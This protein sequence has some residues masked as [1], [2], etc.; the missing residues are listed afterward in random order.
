MFSEEN[1]TDSISFI[2]DYE[3][4]D[5]SDLYRQGEDGIMP[6]LPVSDVMLFPGVVSPIFV[7]TTSASRLL[8]Q[9]ER[10]NSWICVVSQREDVERDRDTPITRAQVYDIGVIAKVARII[11][12]P[13]KSKT[14]MLQTF[15]RCAIGDFV[16]DNPFVLANVQKLE[17]EIPSLDDLHF[18][19]LID[20]IR[21]EAFKMY[22]LT[23][24]QPEPASLIT[25]NIKH[26]IFLTNFLST[27]IHIPLSDKYE[28]L[29]QNKLVDRAYTLLTFIN[30]ETQYGKLRQKIQEK[31]R[32]DLD[33]QQREYF[34]HQQ[35][36]NIKRELGEI[37]GVD[38]ESEVEEIRNKGAK[39]NFPEPIREIF[40]RE[41]RKV[42]HIP[43]QSPDYNVEINHLRTMISLPWGKTTLDRL[44]LRSAQ[45]VLNRDHYGMERVKERILEHLAMMKYRVNKHKSPILCLYGPPGVGKTSLGRSIAESLGRKYVRVSLGGLHDEAEIRGHRRTYVGAMMG[46]IMKSLTKAAT[47]N[48]VFILDEIDKVG[49]NLHNGDPQ[50]ALLEVLDPEQNYAFH[51]NFLDFDYD[52]SQ[53]L[54]IATAN[55][56]N[57]I[58]AALL[59]RMELIRVDGYS[60]EEKREI[61][62]RH[63]IPRE[64]KEIDLGGTI[65]FTPA[66]TDC[67]IERY[68]K[69]EG[70]RQLKAQIGNVVR[71]I[72][73]RTAIDDAIPPYASRIKPEDITALLGDPLTAGVRGSRIS[74]FG[75]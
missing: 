58:P 15:G 2:A 20:N 25:R 4:E 34:L 26:P 19:A 21:D 5:I 72:A 33:Q 73:H 39:V 12:L 14:V 3:G 55:N 74:G 46:R 40:D 41:V 35:I 11:D 62:R 17:E 38:T 42:S 13:R 16:E 49:S 51:D 37:D 10:H 45:R 67:L 63:L 64:L 8:K 70:V 36:K 59:D 43:P 53:V 56:L 23:L 22:Q 54:F 18:N 32:E 68:T 52:L 61:A 6:I 60:L 27:T 57:T 47:D 31:T 48:P 9:A 28:L 24:E 7:T 66:A 69:E 75:K 29:K 1:P 30:R 44:N 65:K 50:S 71:K